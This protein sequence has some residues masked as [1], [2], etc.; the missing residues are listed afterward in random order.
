[1]SPAA[2]ARTNCRAVGCC[3]AAAV[4]LGACATDV[5]IATPT[6]T[7]SGDVT[8]I[9]AEIKASWAPTAPGSGGFRP[10][11]NWD[12]PVSLYATAW[13]LCL[14]ATLKVATPNLSTQA[15]AAELVAQLQKDDPSLPPLQR[16]WLVARS[17]AWLGLPPPVDELRAVLARSRSGDLFS[18][19]PAEPPTWSATKTAL[20]VGVAAGVAPP[21]EVGARARAQLAAA[22]AGATNDFLENVLSLWVVA[23]RVLSNAERTPERAAL[24]SVLQAQVARIGTHPDGVGLL[25]LAPIYGVA[26]ANGIP[27]PALGGGSLKALDTP[28][29]YLALSPTRDYAD[30]QVTCV[31]L[32]MGFH[33]AAPLVDTVARTSQ[34]DGWR[35]WTS[36]TPDVQSSLFSLLALRGLGAPWNE[37]ELRIQTATWLQALRRTVAPSASDLRDWYY[38]LAIARELQIPAPSWLAGNVANLMTTAA[39]D[40]DS[41]LIALAALIGMTAHPDATVLA[42]VSGFSPTTMKQAWNLALAAEVAGQPSWAAHAADVA[43]GLE[44]GHFDFRSAPATPVPDLLSTAAGQ[45]LEGIDPAA[46]ATAT[47]PFGTFPRFSIWPPASGPGNLSDPQAL[48]LGLLASGA[49]RD[50]TGLVLAFLN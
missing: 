24:A 50:S 19:S 17:F 9:V 38:A 26:N 25:V 44:T 20:E 33:P 22:T 36:D 2:L 10:I 3:L 28:Q 39:P 32:S 31:A 8:S 15:V 34:V 11:G 21:P 6:P 4:L 18:Y 47:S 16:A 41:W 46:R 42:R 29:G 49:D 27:L 40:L 12:A 7:S 14:R 48:Y 5:P 30:P 35:V 37:A 23:D 45:Q 1:L 43:R 13:N